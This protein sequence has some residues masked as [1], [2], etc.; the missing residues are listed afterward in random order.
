M[1]LEH[2]FILYV[3]STKKDKPILRKAF[4]KRTEEIAGKFTQMFG[5]ATIEPALGYWQM[6]NGQAVK[7]TIN[8]VVSYCTAEQRNNHM[9]KIRGMAEAKRLEWEQ[10]A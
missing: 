8:K 3:P 4:N 10:E 1:K 5:G 7:E 2:R 9:R 6:E